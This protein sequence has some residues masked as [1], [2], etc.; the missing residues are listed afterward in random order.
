MITLDVNNTE[1]AFVITDIIL[2][3]IQNYLFW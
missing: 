3:C 1:E 2:I